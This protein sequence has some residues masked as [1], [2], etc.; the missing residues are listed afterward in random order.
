MADVNRD[1]STWAQTG[2]K[3]SS[4]AQ[5]WTDAKTIYGAELSILEMLNI[6]AV[7]TNR[8]TPIF[9]A[10]TVNTNADTDL[11]GVGGGTNL[12]TQLPDFSLGTFITDYDFYYNS[13]R[14]QPG[15]NVGA[16]N[17]IY[18]GTS[19]ANGQVRFAEKVR[20]AA[21]A[22]R[23]ADVFCVVPWV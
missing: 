20:A 16:G 8:G 14:I 18:P 10:V 2:V 6:A 17:D 22:G 5:D 23:P 1:T 3:L 9:S 15:A 19:P 11:G 7:N 12:D 4:V 21:G 13:G